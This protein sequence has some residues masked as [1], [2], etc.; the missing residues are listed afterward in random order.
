MI[1]VNSTNKPAAMDHSPLRLAWLLLL[2]ATTPGWGSP[3]VTMTNWARRS[4]GNGHFYEAVATS[5]IIWSSASAG[6]TNRG[7]YLATITSTQENQVVFELIRGNTNLWTR[8]PSTD[9]WGPWLGGV[10]PPGSQEPAGGWS[11]ITSEPFTYQHW[12]IG[13]P[14]NNAAGEDRIHFIGEKAPVGDV[15]N[16]SPSTNGA[17]RSYVVEYEQNLEPA[18]I[19]ELLFNEAGANAANTGSST[20][21]PAL[22]TDSTGAIADLHSVNGGGVSGFAGDRA[23]DNSAAT[24]MGSSGSGGRGRQPYDDATDG[25]VSITL[26][27][28][29]KASSVIGSLARIFAKQSANT[30]FLLL[31]TGS[32]VLSLEINNVARS[33]SSGQYSEIGQWVFFAVTYDGTATTNNVRFYK[34]STITPVALLETRTLNQGKAATN[35]AGVTYANADGLQ[36]PLDGF[37]DNLR[38]F[39]S[40]TD[41]RGAMTASQLEWFRNKDVQNLIDVPAISVSRANGRLLVVWT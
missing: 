33:I 8:R 40:K 17:I 36:R 25:L 31:A 10:Q 22:F 18:P 29:F 24:G 38:I 16:D 13:E 39:G 41:G 5:G 34:G 2:G 7:G 27:G 20:S 35:N 32:G 28:W 30:G 11:W 14:N 19:I 3:T 9:S 21:G 6:A 26:Q 15:W 4:G 12:N 23:F 37:L 1:A